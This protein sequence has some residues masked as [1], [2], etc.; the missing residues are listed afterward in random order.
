M[1]RQFTNTTT[2][3]V[4]DLDDLNPLMGSYD[5]AL[6]EDELA[7]RGFA[8]ITFGLN[9]KS[10]QDQIVQRLTKGEAIINATDSPN[11]DP[12][13]ELWIQLLGEY[14]IVSDAMQSIL[15]CMRRAS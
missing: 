5:E 2:G 1:T 9:L 4:V 13:N 12:R 14:K 10:I 3:D 7:D 11:S 8:L 6:Y 15:I